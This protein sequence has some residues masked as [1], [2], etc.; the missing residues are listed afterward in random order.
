MNQTSHTSSTT[1]PPAGLAAERSATELPGGPVA[2]D[3][4]S[5]AAAG[6]QLPSFEIPRALH[7]LAMTGPDSA[8][9]HSGKPLQPSPASAEPA[10]PAPMSSA[11]STSSASLGFSPAWAESSSGAFAAERPVHPT[12]P[13]TETSRFKRLAL[14]SLALLLAAVSFGGL[15]GGNAVPNHWDRSGAFR[16][17]LLGAST[18]E[19]DAP[20]AVH[21]RLEVKP[22][23]HPQNSFAGITTRIEKQTCWWRFCGRYR[24][25]TG[26]KHHPSTR[27]HTVTSTR[28]FVPAAS[29]DRHRVRYR[30]PN[31]GVLLRFVADIW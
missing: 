25:V 11:E 21:V 23:N 13:T 29:G 7:A 1:G 12:S 30:K 24:A 3:G 22:Y 16:V 20:V 9:V 6:G 26:E 14:L 15:A 31:D 27:W 8:A 5:P 19:V 18:F 4:S 10:Q 28:V 2:L 17:N